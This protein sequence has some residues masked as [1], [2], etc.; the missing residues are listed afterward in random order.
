MILIR[1]LGSAFNKKKQKNMGK[2]LDLQSNHPEIKKK[3]S[4]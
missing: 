3:G 4:R 1:A 2:T